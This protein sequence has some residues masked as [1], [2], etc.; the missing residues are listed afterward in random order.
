MPDLTITVSDEELSQLTTMGAALGQTARKVAQSILHRNLNVAGK[1]PLVPNLERAADR[2][3]RQLEIMIMI[4]RRRRLGPKGT[5]ILTMA[6]RAQLAQKHGVTVRTITRDLEV[7]VLA[8][9]R[10]G[11]DEVLTLDP[12]DHEHTAVA[13]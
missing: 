12:D 6:E 2:G 13:S 4:R 9:D 11:H 10:A 1:R 3:R 7:A 8:L 5:P